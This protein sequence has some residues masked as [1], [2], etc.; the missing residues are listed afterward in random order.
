MQ[1]A[2]KAL[3]T[4]VT[5]FAATNLDDILVLTVFFG[6]VGSQ[7]LHRWHII[8]GQYLGFGALVLISLIGFFSNFLIPRSWIGLLGILPVVIGLRRWLRDRNSDTRPS[9]VEEQASRG[10]VITVASVTFAN[11]GDN[12][13]IYAP[14]F[15]SL[16]L[17]ALFFTVAVFFALIGVWCFL[18]GVLG[19]H[20]IVIAGL[21]RYGHAIVPFVFIGIGLYILVD[22]GTLLHFLR[23]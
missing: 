9:I 1:E 12:I 14:L 2:V 8:A 18:G 17:S 16:T 20:P 3:I 23:P 22:S 15:A 5:A 19:S 10:W 11:G 6:Q 7:G 13:G 4:A 21:S